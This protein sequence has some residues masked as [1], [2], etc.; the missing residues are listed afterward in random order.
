[1]ADYEID[2][3]TKGSPKGE[4]Q[5]RDERPDGRTIEKKWIVNIKKL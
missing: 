2:N 1:M 4:S 5:Y 3:W